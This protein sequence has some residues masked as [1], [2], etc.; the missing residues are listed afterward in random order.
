MN[1]YAIA[2]F[3]VA[4]PGIVAPAM[5]QATQQVTATQYVEAQVA[6]I[7]G[8]AELLTLN[9]IAQDPTAVAEAMEQLAQLTEGLASLKSSINADELAVA[10]D[11][12]QNDPET[13]M[14]GQM[15]IAAV[16]A[17]SSK[18]FYNCERLAIAVQALSDAMEK[19]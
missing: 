19:L 7:K 8:A 1:K 10:E 13:H 5:A 12:A 6:I 9:S 11:A 18:N 17:A 15:F 4:V 2:A 14:A 16:N 3:A